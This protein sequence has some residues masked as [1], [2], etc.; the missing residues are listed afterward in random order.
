MSRKSLILCLSVLGVVLVF[1]GAAVAV[2]YSGVDDSQE[3]I[4]DDVPSV[5][6]AVP[7]D[8]MLVA[9][10]KAA[11]LCQFSDVLAD[12]LKRCDAAVSLHYSGRLH[13]LSVVDVRKIDAN[14]QDALRCYLVQQG[15]SVAQE[16]RLILFSSSENIL[17]SAVRHLAEGVSVMDAPGFTDAYESVKGQ[18]ILLV[19][20]QHARR[21]MSSV[22]TSKVYKHASF[23]SK[24]ADW[25]AFMIREDHGLS[26]FGNLI[27]D[28]DPDELLT[29][30]EDCVPGVPEFAD[31]LPSYT[32][33]AL[34][35]PM[36]NHGTFREDFQVF[37][38]SRNNLKPMLARQNELKKKNGVSPM[39]LFDRLGV[40]EL[41][42]AGIMI[43]SRLERVILIRIDS[44]NADLIFRDPSIT[45]MRGYVSKL[46][47]WKYQS[48]VSS[49]YGNMFAIA[50]ES[51]FTYR[52][53]WLII[54]SRSAIDEY[55][56]HNALEYTLSEYVAHAGRKSLLTASPAIA[57]AYFS[58]TAEKDKL[59]D[60]MN[61]GMTDGLKAFIGEPEYS[62]VVFHIGR[63]E[64]TM[65]SSLDIY[66]LTL[67]RTKAPTT[68][69]DTTVIVP[70]RPF[71]VLKSSNGK[72]HK[73]Y[74]NDYK[75]LCLRDENGKNLWG[76]PFDKTI[77]GRAHG[78]DVH[79]NGREHIIFGAGSSLYVIDRPGRYVTGF[80]LDLKKEIC[81]GPDVYE[82]S[83]QKCA[84]VLHTDN[85]LEL[86]TLP[87]GKRPSF[88]H[89]I[90]LD[91]ETIKSLPETLT[92]GQKDFWI[93]RTAIQTLIFPIGGGKALTN[94]KG[95]A[96]IRP[97]SE[98]LIREDGETV[99][100]NCY[101]GKRRTVNLK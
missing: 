84:A 92:A 91:D 63:S 22:F 2:L 18:S 44:R 40:K 9:C 27:Y 21:L 83:G 13:S 85:T 99:E 31:Y 80:P 59:S 14:V 20:G 43:R 4:S 10:G 97:D 64:D 24:I 56:T 69:R 42:T 34:T 81:L 46:H 57:L 41:A 65:T 67:G 12:Q 66:G 25:Y 70:K 73:F 33:Y 77:C 5:L 29:A 58:L 16:G 93:V 35:L 36:A 94:F 96:K 98:V 30:F 28:G 87:K 54:G 89:T 68:S 60:Y 11:G 38:D 7:A 47:T 52:N 88:W 86:Y 48:Y 71:P 75:S 3:V 72:S 62:P 15:K 6:S 50:D 1:V 55:V 78:V 95:D 74:Q 39:E 79:D 51:C 90:D 23:L 17:K 37:A 26:F 8:A 32:L 49:V 19:P 101:D 45:T 82:I 53:G 61:K 76:V 100:V